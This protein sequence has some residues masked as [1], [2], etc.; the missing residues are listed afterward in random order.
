M[1]GTARRRRVTLAITGASLAAA[2]MTA[3]A[4]Q[5]SAVTVANW[6]MNES[7]G[8]TVMH[9]S[10]GHGINGSIG[11]DVVTGATYNG[12]VG[13]KFST[14]QS[15]VPNS[16]RLVRASSGA[17]NPGT[18]DFAVTIRFRTFAPTANLIQKGQATTPGGYFKLEQPDAGGVHC[19]FGGAKGVVGVATG[20]AVDD[21]VWHT[22]RCERT[23]T[24]VTMT[25]DG[26]VTDKQS[27][28]TGAISNTYPVTI[29]GKL[30]CNQSPVDCDYFSGQTDYVTIKAS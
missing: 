27:G 4:A 21:G 5:A 12:S 11:S 8:A 26:V 29:G 17:L 24:A 18:R 10:S 2:V 9:D 22:V 30:S 7:A 13:Y 3:G 25:V 16:G 1:T 20:R 19:V 23:P 6:Q 15:L 28:S 14:S